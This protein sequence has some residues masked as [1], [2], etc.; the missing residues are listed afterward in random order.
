MAPVIVVPKSAFRLVRGDLKY[1]AVTGDSGN[2][3]G[4][5]FC[6]SCGRRCDACSNAGLDGDQG[7]KS[8][9]ACALQANDEHLSVERAAVGTYR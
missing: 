7:G 9:R 1:H 2:E 6:T 8:G 5:G 3:V 4:R